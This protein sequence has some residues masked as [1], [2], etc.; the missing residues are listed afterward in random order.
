LGDPDANATVASVAATASA[1]KDVR[2]AASAFMA[3][4]TDAPASDTAIAV[5]SPSDATTEPSENAS[6]TQPRTK[7]PHLHKRQH[8]HGVHP[9]S[10]GNSGLYSPGGGAAEPPSLSK[11]KAVLLALLE[12]LERA[13]VRTALA[14]S[15]R[16]DKGVTRKAVQKLALESIRG[17]A[18]ASA[19]APDAS[20]VPTPSGQSSE[21]TVA[22]GE[23]TAPAV[24]VPA[25]DFLGVAMNGFEGPFPLLRAPAGATAV[26]PMRGLRILSLDGGGIRGLAELEVLREIERVTSRRIS[27]LFDLVIGT[28]TGG[29]LSI[30]VCMQ[31]P[32]NEIEKDYWKIRDM[33][34]QAPII[35]EFKRIATGTSHSSENADMILSSIFGDAGLSDLPP[36]PKCVVVAANVD[37]Y[38]LQPYLFR[39]YEHSREAFSAAEVLG[40][41][42]VKAAEAARATTAAPTVFDPAIIGR[43]RYV[44]GA[45]IA[46]NPLWIGLSELA[47]LWPGRPIDAIVSLGTGLMNMRPFTPTSMLHWAKALVDLAT[48]PMTAHKVA[49][50]LF[51]PERYFRFDAPVVGDVLL[52][53]GRDEVILDMVAKTRE[54]IA[55]ENGK[56]AALCKRLL[57]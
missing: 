33:L 52:D 32:L 27:D 12:E 10:R 18:R 41:S 51:S 14:E 15:A 40:T 39:S 44:D 47:L 17:E 54:Y 50:T 23:T 6:T 34:A 1:S 7:Q 53:E 13:E 5:Q 30:L 29:F 42:L 38:P 46:N 2:N 3:T 45:V 16:V 26:R 36:M 48:N 31:R 55:R 21:L 8:L 56:F 19:L 49:A 11:T 9:R 43:G 28:S 25:F 22:S 20:S 57:N 35:S 24:C 4:A 37:T